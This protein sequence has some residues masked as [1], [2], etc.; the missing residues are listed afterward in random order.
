MVGLSDGR[1]GLTSSPLPPSRQF[2]TLPFLRRVQGWIDRIQHILLV[3][4]G[5]TP[6]PKPIFL[7]VNHA[8]GPE[9]MNSLGLMTLYRTK[10]AIPAIRL[11]SI[12]QI[13]ILQKCFR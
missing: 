9:I 10:D 5:Q 6:T 8:T 13:I 2:V 4:S 7:I 1:K 11:M 3:A 12:L